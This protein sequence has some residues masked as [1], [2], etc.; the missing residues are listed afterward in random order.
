MKNLD[1]R[2]MSM[3]KKANNMKK[4]IITPKHPYTKLFLYLWKYLLTVKVYINRNFYIFCDNT[5]W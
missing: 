4:D 1:V 2:Y 3:D 5:N